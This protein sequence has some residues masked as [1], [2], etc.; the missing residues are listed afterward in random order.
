LKEPAVANAKPVV[1][2]LAKPHALLLISS[3]PKGD[4]GM[5][6]LRKICQPNDF[7]PV[8]SDKTRNPSVLLGDFWFITKNS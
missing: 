2:P 8:P 5:L 6:E 1:S 7:L 3:A 4:L